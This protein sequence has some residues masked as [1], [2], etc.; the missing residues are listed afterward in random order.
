MRV[1]DRLRALAPNETPNPNALQRAP[2]RICR[3]LDALRTISKLSPS[4]TIS[5]D[6]A[7]RFPSILPGTDMS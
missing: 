6:G 5:G 7:V 3:D 1:E 2:T 4:T